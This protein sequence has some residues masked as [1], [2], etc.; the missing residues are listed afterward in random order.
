MS[1]ALLRP[2]A[3]REIGTA[4]SSRGDRHR[5]KPEARGEIGSVPSPLS[6]VHALVPMTYEL[7][8]VPALV[9]IVYH[10]FGSSPTFVTSMSRQLRQHPRTSRY[11]CKKSRMVP[12]SSQIA[13]DVP[14]SSQ[15]VKNGTVS[16]Q[17]VNDEQV[18]SRE[19]ST[20]FSTKPCKKSR[21]SWIIRNFLREC[22]KCSTKV[23]R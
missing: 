3:H 22:S 7:K 9:Q 19:V 16:S 12:I 8:L 4:P 14:I 10:S 20:K 18:S 21:L 1:K 15:E 17:E 11:L 23:G 5:N 2:E 13:K 6:L